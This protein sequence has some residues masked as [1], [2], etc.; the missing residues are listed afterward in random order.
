MN[1][2]DHDEGFEKE[3]RLKEMHKQALQTLDVLYSW[4]K[5]MD[6]ARILNPELCEGAFSRRPCRRKLRYIGYGN[7][8]EPT[9]SN[10]I[11]RDY[12]VHGEIYYSTDFNGGTYSI[13]GYSES[14]DGRVVG[15]AY[16]EWLVDE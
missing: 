7:R 3:V 8:P 13:E 2:G 15:C 11:A 14:N 10:T 16:F 6:I 1:I 9:G 4:R 5:F 12:F